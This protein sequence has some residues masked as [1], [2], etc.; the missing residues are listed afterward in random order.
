LQATA[1]HF[2]YVF[3]RQEFPVEASSLK[4]GDILLGAKLMEPLKIIKIE[5]VTNKGFFSQ[6][7]T[8]G[9]VAVN[10]I[11]ASNFFLWRPTPQ[12]ITGMGS[13]SRS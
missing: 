1:G 13:T 7:T 8:D 11:V 12:P 6:L 10:G 9:T 5:T 2:V 4:K 3:D